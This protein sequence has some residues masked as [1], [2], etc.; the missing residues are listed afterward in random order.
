M[1]VGESPATHRLVV[2]TGDL[3]Y[4][5]RK[6]ILEIDAALPGTDWLILL[7]APNKTLRQLVRS[8]WLNL[9]RNGW[10]WIPY[11]LADIVRRA[12]PGSAAAAAPPGPGSEYS[13]DALRRR[14]NVRLE[15]VADIHGTP[16]L[17]MLRR[18]DAELGLSLAAP[19]LRRPAFALPARGTINLHKGKLPDFRGMPP[20]FWELWHDQA[21]VGCS[22]HCVDERLDT[23]ALIA[24]ASVPRAPHATLRGLQLQLD[25][26]GIAL[27][28]RTVP[29]LLAGHVQP[30]PQPAGEGATH[31]KPTLEQQAQL[32]RKLAPR[33]A[34][35]AQPKRIL[36][37]AAAEAVVRLHRLGLGKLAAPRITVLLYHRV[38]DDVRDNLSV[39]IEQFDRQMAL[40]A[41]HC[42]VLPIDQVLAAESVPR[43][44][45][46]MVAVTFDDGYLDNFQQAA[47]I[48]RRHG[49]PAAFFVS[50]GIVD[51]ANRFP[52]DLRRGNAPIP[53]MRWD[54]LRAMRQWGFTIGSHTVNHIDCAAEPE[55]I[56]CD[57]LARSRDDLRR[58]LGVE[59]PIFAY[60]Y[61][62]R[63]HMTAQRLERVREAG[64]VGCL[65]AYG[66]TNIGRVDRFNVLRR[67]IHWEFSDRALM[68]E[69]LGLT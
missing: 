42:R 8:Q 58:E 29:A 2:F 64:Y 59:Q 65:S 9:H 14:G 31:R 6:G 26:V 12:L 32:R 38:S 49:I 5:V 22:V 24:E 33:I 15:R 13:L 66:G 51:S 40:L 37:E 1:A 41:R 21:S 45:Q 63:Q 47:P 60:P 23:G 16:A 56:V 27:M 44:A 61:G 36:K 3:S 67:G 68:L 43:S 20:A 52:H 7:H 53:V 11:Q 50:T 10:R 28:A 18:F 46:P 19:I 55:D 4:A 35:A 62:G 34:L 30:R 48:L 17:D 57:E 54:D 39:G 25:E 69:C